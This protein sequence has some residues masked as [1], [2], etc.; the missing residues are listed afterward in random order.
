[1]LAKQ[2][3]QRKQ[4]MTQ[5]AT[6]N[7]LEYI[8]SLR[9]TAVFLHV[10]GGAQASLFSVSYRGIITRGQLGEVLLGLFSWISLSCSPQ[11]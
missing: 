3:T 11:Q 1:M 6:R 9:S 2:L 8:G 4:S 10:T 5:Q 7:I